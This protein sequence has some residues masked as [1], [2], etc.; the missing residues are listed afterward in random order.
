MAAEKEHWIPDEDVIA[1]PGCSEKVLQEKQKKK[2]EHNS[3]R[4]TSFLCFVLSIFNIFIIF[5]SSLPFLLGF[6]F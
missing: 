6:F 3:I 1:C 4:F 2:K 5:N